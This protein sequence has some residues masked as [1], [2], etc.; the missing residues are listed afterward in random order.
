MGRSLSTFQSRQHDAPT[1][2]AWGFVECP[3]LQAVSADVNCSVGLDPKTEAE[4]WLEADTDDS[5]RAIVVVQMFD[6]SAAQTQFESA[7]KSNGTHKPWPL[8]GGAPFDKDVL[9]PR[10]VPPDWRHSAVQTN[11]PGGLGIKHAWRGPGRGLILRY[12]LDRG[13]FLTEPLFQWTTQNLRILPTAWRIDVPVT[14]KD[15]GD[16]DELSGP[17]DLGDGSSAVADEIAPAVSRHA[18]VGA[19][20]PLDQNEEEDL[21][22]NVLRGWDHLKLPDN[23]STSEALKVLKKEIHRLR[24]GFAFLKPNVRHNISVA[25]GSVWGHLLTKETSWEW[26]GLSLDGAEFL[27]VVS[28]DRACAISPVG[29]IQQQ[30]AGDSDDTVILLFNMIRGGNLPNAAPGEYRMLS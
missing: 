4:I 22:A 29:F 16:D 19:A 20:R 13:D 2:L 23:A 6:L 21:I 8:A 11:T 25:L 7:L 1:T 24:P 27:A 14:Q 28:P 18:S 15:W 10:Q 3:D 30:L 17:D 12:M 26:C 9:L 5:G